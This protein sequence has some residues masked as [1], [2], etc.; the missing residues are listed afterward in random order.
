MDGSQTEKRPPRMDTN[1]LNS[2]SCAFVQFVAN[3][4]LTC[5]M[6]CTLASAQPTTQPTADW[7]PLF[8]GKDFAG[9]YTYLKG[10]GKDVD[11]THVFSVDDGMIHIYKDAED[12]AT[13]PFGYLATNDEFGECRIRLEYKWGTKRF[14]TRSTSRR[15]SGL[16]YFFTGADGAFGKGPWPCSIEC[17]IQEND[18]GDIYFVGTEGA[19]TVDP[20]KKDAK[21]QTFKPAGDP[22]STPSADNIRVIRSEMLEQDGWNTVEVVLQ[23]DSA[24]HII[25]GKVNNALTNAKAPDPANPAQMISV[26]K[27]KILLQAE[28]AEVW[29][30]KV[31]VLAPSATTT[32]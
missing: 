25:N 2:H 32:R 8:N 10:S 21:Q 23:G 4:F 11:P 20:S 5:L 14:G 18:V 24:T 3:S 22:Y 26:K 30:R 31:E 16:L 6:F 28:G 19:T 7:K 12:G 9:W 13:Q 29:Y 17:Q 1:Q 27:G 15:D